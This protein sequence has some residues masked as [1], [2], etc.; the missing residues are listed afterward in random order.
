MLFTLI[1]G[2]CTA[3]GTSLLM[4]TDYP[5]DPHKLIDK[6][7]DHPKVVRILEMPGTRL[8]SEATVRRLNY[9]K[10][11]TQRG[12]EIINTLTYEALEGRLV[13]AIE[14]RAS[15]LRG[16]KIDRLPHVSFISW[17]GLG[18]PKAPRVTLP[19]GVDLGQ[20]GDDAIRSIEAH[21]G[22]VGSDNRFKDNTG[23]Y[24]L[25]YIGM[26]GAP[27]KVIIAEGK[28]Y[29]VEFGRCNHR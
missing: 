18:E 8:R 20:S 26:G 6:P 12:E 14:S 16:R 24:I 29:R 15:I 5:I 11:G 23:G 10:D 28:V 17:E 25:P 7:A 9:S 13:I 2:A 3:W 4:A 27:V 19:F 1:F 21:L 22:R